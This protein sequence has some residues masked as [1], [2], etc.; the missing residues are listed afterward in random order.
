MQAEPE[1]RRAMARLYGV[2]LPNLLTLCRLPLAAMLWWAPGSAWW[3]LSC[4]ALSSLTDIADGWLV[5]RWRPER[6]RFES[7]ETLAAEASRGAFL[8]GLA[9]KVF[10]GSAVAAL[11]VAVAPPLHYAPLLVSRELLMVPLLALHRLLPN[12][13]VDYRSALLGRAAT[14]TQ[15]VALILG[16]LRHP[17]FGPAAWLAG[18]TGAVAALFYVARY[19]RGR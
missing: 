12:R 10:V 1:R 3:V 14:T 2:R 9:D 17:A 7:A 11:F 15:F 6:A 4:M 8:D 19:V 16:F 13:R 5:R 18:A